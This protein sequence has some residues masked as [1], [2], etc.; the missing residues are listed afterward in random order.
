[1]KRGLLAR[2]GQLRPA[3]S[4]H[5]IG[6]GMRAALELGAARRCDLAMLYRCDL[7]ML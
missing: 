4:C 3:P 6:I 5:A 2:Q 7:A 1:M